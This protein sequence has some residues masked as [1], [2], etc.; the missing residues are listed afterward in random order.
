MTYE[1]ELDLLDCIAE[2]KRSIWDQYQVKINIQIAKSVSM[3]REN[4]IST[5][6]IHAIEQYSGKD[7]D[8]IL[9][10]NTRDRIKYKQIYIG[11]MLANSEI[12][13]KKL[14]QQVQLNDHTSALYHR[15]KYS[16]YYSTYDDFVEM[17]H[18]ILEIVN[19]DKSLPKVNAIQ[20]DIYDKH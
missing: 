14:A 11:L 10:R 8:D 13:L 20:S 2:F 17:V 12:S 16:D 4:Q 5:R 6:L 7:W 15:D 19:T 18:R 3:S 1:Q 9:S